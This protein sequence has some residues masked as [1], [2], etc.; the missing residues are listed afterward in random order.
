MRTNYP[1]IEETALPLSF[2]DYMQLVKGDHVEDV[3]N[4]LTDI[5]NEIYKYRKSDIA[6]VVK[7][8]IPN[9]EEDEL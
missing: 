6:Q 2:E 7:S 3:T 5:H 1:E 8:M 9:D 4:A